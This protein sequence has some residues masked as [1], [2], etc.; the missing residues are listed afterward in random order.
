MPN[1][2]PQDGFSYPTLTLMIDSYSI[3]PYLLPLWLL[4]QRGHAEKERDRKGFGSINAWV[5]V[6]I[7]QNP[8]L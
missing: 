5:K 3:F 2:D 1:G 4:L 6:Q 7:F 8:A